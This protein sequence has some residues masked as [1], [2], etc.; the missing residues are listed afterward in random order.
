MHNKATNIYLPTEISTEMRILIVNGSI[1]PVQLYGGTERVIWGLGKALNQLGHEITYL[2]GKGSTCDF[3]SIIEIDTDRPILNQIP[4]EFDVVHFNFT[5]EG[6]DNFELPYI[7]TIHGNAGIDFNFD[8]NSVFVSKNHAERYDSQSYVYNGLDWDEYSKPDLSL[9][10]DFFH[11]LG[12]AAWRVKNVQGAID[13][14]KIIPNEKLYVLGGSRFNFSMGLRFTFSPKVRFF[15]MIGG[16][17]KDRLI[18]RSKGLVFP[19]KWHEPFGL[20]IIESLFYGCPVFATPYGSL[21]ELVAPEV[22]FLSNN[23]KDL[24]QALLSWNDYSQKNCHEYARDCFNANLMAKNYLLKYEQV[25][26]GKK[27]NTTKPKP[28]IINDSKF[29]DWY[30]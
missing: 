16:Q 2:V 23:R 24:S 14:I 8:I 4:K 17:K 10:R 30:N 22:G 19:I 18:N 9:K 3:G 5:P 15:G 1:I 21:P 20:A 26:Q 27:L 7:I 28:K 13:V 29:L 6:I 11:F 25:I 12:K